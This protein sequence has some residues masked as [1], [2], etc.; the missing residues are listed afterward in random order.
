[1]SCWLEAPCPS[2]EVHGCGLPAGGVLSGPCIG[3]ASCAYEWLCAVVAWRLLR[4]ETLQRS[5]CTLHTEAVLVSGSWRFFFSKGSTTRSREYCGLRNA[6]VCVTCFIYIRLRSLCFIFFI[7]YMSSQSGS[8]TDQHFTVH[9]M[10]VHV[11]TRFD[12]GS[13]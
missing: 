10:S 4:T 12:F 8:Q 3:A 9:C 5:S 7:L 2:S 11:T 13:I 6:G 1:M